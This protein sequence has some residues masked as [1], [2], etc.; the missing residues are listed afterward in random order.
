MAMRD[1]EKARMLDEQ[2][3]AEE[4][5]LGKARAASG[6]AP[7]VSIVLPAHNEAGHIGEVARAFLEAALGAGVEAEVI[8]VDDA[9]HDGTSEAAKRGARGDARVRVLRREAQGGYGGALRTG[10]EAA[11]GEWVFFTDG[12][13]QFSADDL[14][15]FLALTRAGG[16]DMVLGYRHPRQDDGYRRALGRAWTA[17][18]GALLRIEVRDMNCAYKIVRRGA[19]ERMGLGSRGALI[20]A[21]LLHK[22][23]RLGLRQVQRPVRHLKRTEGEATGARPEVIARALWELARYRV[24]SLWV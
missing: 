17:L 3:S 16:V 12:D 22:A 9:S 20:N 10:F 24:E 6:E 7:W 11:R 19:L 5:G 15:E 4:P 13:G 8:V 2:G 18:S 21:E 1:E 23:R 14:G